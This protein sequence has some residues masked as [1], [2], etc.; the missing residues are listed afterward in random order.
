MFL[1][2]LFAPPQE[3]PP[4]RAET[5]SRRREAAEPI[6][7]P[8]AGDAFE[9]EIFPTWT[10]TGWDMSV[11]ELR[12]GIDRYISWAEQVVRDGSVDIARQHAPHRARDLERTLNAHFGQ[13]KWSCRHEGAVLRFTASVRVAPEERVREFLRPY[14]VDRITT[15]C[16]HELKKLE[17]RH[18]DE[19]TRAWRELLAGLD[20]DPVTSHAA[21]LTGKDFAEVFAQYLREQEAVVPRLEELLDKAL[22]G[23]ADLGMGPAEY[24]E[25][26]DVALRAYQRR[27]PASGRPD[28]RR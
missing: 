27:Y 28:Q 11:E 9:F 19:L 5:V 12:Q 1:S 17:V 24:T 8:A 13:Q 26:W 18:A 21:R 20:H 16:R 25:A 14:W 23:H 3:P 10:W 4:P 2:R 6:R 7:V 22:K 15:E